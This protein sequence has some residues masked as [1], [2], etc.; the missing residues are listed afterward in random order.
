MAIAVASFRIEER[1]GSILRRDRLPTLGLGLTDLEA[2]T[3][4]WVL[5]MKMIIILI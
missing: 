2:G 1:L 4:L 5:R 3:K